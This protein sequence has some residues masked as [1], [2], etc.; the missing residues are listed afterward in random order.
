MRISTRRLCRLSIRLL[1]VATLAAS[2]A[3][4]ASAADV[5]LIQAVKNG[6]ATAVRALLVTGAPTWMRGRAT[7]RPPSTGPPT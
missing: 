2:A 7:A 4:G 5:E 1:I 6:D 3:N